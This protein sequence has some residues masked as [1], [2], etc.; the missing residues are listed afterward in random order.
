MREIVPCD[1]CE[2]REALV[3]VLVSQSPL[4]I[5]GSGSRAGFGRPGDA[6]GAKLSMRR[7]SNVVFYEPS[8]L[9]VRVGAGALLAQHGQEFA[10]EP[11]RHGAL[12][13]VGADGDDG[14]TIGGL[15]AV[16]ASGPRRPKAG[17]A[18][19]HLLGFRS[20]T[21]RGDLVKSGGRVMKNVT[22]FDLSK[23]VCGSHG[24]L[25]ALCEATF[26]VLPKAER[27]CTLSC[28]PPDEERGLALLRKASG[29][30]LDASGFAL[31][32]NAREGGTRARLR[33]EGSARSVRARKQ[34]LRA[35]FPDVTFEEA[36]DVDSQALW[37]RLRDAEP[38]AA[39]G[40]VVWRISVAP[41]QAFAT[42]RGVERAGVPLNAYFYDWVGGLIWLA[43]A[44][45]PDAHAGAT[46]SQV[47]RVGG[48]A[49]LMRAPPEIRSATPVFHPQPA[50]LAALTRRVKESFDPLH[51]L[52]RG[53]MRPD[54]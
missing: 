49:T 28:A 47:D 14:G 25:A 45:S 12:Y 6:A 43:A 15:I 39:A 29:L 30:P 23:L 22:G 44:T 18:R 34:A 24:T 50:A 51:L 1:E 41:S 10:F 52:N 36:D 37:K 9:V 3:G 16:N 5:V 54:F 42:M 26:K 19:D 4:D 35:A 8:E 7:L 13:G 53:R 17:A 46:R 20:V 11:M 27:E 32:P 31:E 40:G 48:H 33:L 21:G 2:L 38:V